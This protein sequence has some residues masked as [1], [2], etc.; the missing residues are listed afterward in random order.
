MQALLRSMPGTAT[1]A[2]LAL[3]RAFTSL[4]VIDVS[5]LLEPDQVRGV[6]SFSRLVSGNDQ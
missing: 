5:A 6:F 1:H 2:Q 4:P 3:Q